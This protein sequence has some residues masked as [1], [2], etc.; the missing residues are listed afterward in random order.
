MDSESDNSS[1]DEDMLKV[2]EDEDTIHMT[3]QP[4][5]TGFGPFGSSNVLNPA[6][7]SPNP[8]SP[9]AAN[10]MSFQRRIR[11]GR[12]TRKSSSSA[13][14][15][16]SMHSPGPTSPL[17]KSIET[18]L[19]G[20]YF[21]KELDKKGI[22]SRRESLSLG[23]N[24][25]HISD[26]TESEEPEAFRSSSND[27]LGLPVNSASNL[28]ERRSVIRRA[29]TRRSNMLVCMIHLGI[30][31]LLTAFK[32]KP[33]TFARIRAALQE[34]VSPVDTESRREAEVIRQVRENDD[35][36]ESNVVPSQSG[37]A[38]SS[39]S[40]AA[41]AGATDSLDDLAEMIGGESSSER[42]ASTN[43]T[44]QALKN[45]G[46]SE[47]WNSFDERMRTPPPPLFPRGSSSTM[48]E[49]MNVDTPASSLAC[50]NSQYWPNTR[51]S[52]PSRSSTPQ[53]MPTANEV[54]R[55]TLGKRRRDDDLDP[56]MFK[57]RAV[58]PGL[59]LQNSPILPPSPAQREGG[60]W[61]TKA[62]REGSIHAPGE[63]ASSGSSTNG[64]GPLG[65]RV[66]LQGMTDTNDGLMNMSIE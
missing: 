49:D 30:I 5:R 51:N 19:S 25:L 48:S 44:K 21:S 50:G 65:K 38:A 59:S 13:S 27:A 11:N 42:R 23:T 2:G 31:H 34:E 15:Q 63:R 41:V 66:G 14:R 29:V 58:S 60:W 55:K 16:S 10:L 8:F 32:P 18:G 36:Q 26:G 62:H 40:I 28:D 20:S 39:P 47:F 4:H 35:G 45:S 52:S 33:K 6:I 17:L 61:Q 37:T 57:R 24:E 1:S 3:P 64:S 56:N 46:G 43:F 7:E 22:E 9:A 12:N 54:T 53:P